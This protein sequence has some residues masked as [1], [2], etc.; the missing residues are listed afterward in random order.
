MPIGNN[1]PIFTS[2]L[3][4][5][6][7]PVAKK[8]AK[9]PTKIQKPNNTW[10]PRYISLNIP[11]TDEKVSVGCTKTIRK[12]DIDINQPSED[13][14]QIIKV[15]FSFIAACD[16]FMLKDA[17]YFTFTMSR[18]NG[19]YKNEGFSV[20]ATRQTSNGVETLKNIHLNKEV[21]NKIVDLALKD[22]DKKGDEQA[23]LILHYVKVRIPNLST[24][25][26]TTP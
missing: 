4:A 9:K 19:K 26:K 14:E 20:V 6:A 7:G 10:E 15:N 17:D 18:K 8:D 23:V 16:N 11:D 3:F 24:Y 5:A 12:A 22:A 1:L 2:S 13:G 21:L 25:Q